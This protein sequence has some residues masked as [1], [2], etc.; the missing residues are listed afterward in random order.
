MDVVFNG[1]ALRF[2]KSVSIDGSTAAFFERL[3][4]HMH[5]SIAKHIMASF[6]ESKKFNQLG[7][8]NLALDVEVSNFFIFFF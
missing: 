7:I 1:P 6:E 5:K 3:L 2:I 8:A 4:F